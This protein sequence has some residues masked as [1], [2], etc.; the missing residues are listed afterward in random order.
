MKRKIGLLLLIV[1]IIIQFIPVALNQSEVVP[2]E[3]F[4]EI[5]QPSD[6]VAL[7]ITYSCYDCH[8]ENTIYP[9]YNKIAPVSWW[10]NHHVEEGKNE[11]NF[12]AW[13]TYS[14][15]R[16]KHKLEE[17][18]EMIEENEMPLKSYLIAHRDAELSSEQIEI[19]KNWI[20]TIK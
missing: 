15:K 14:D 17:I 2:K 9:W 18:V 20:E 7:I 6:E 1:F 3:D 11:L 10:I 13:D 19:L 16:K 8:S 4:I 5:I 12:S